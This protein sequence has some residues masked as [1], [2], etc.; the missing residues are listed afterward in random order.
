MIPLMRMG[1]FLSC[2]IWIRHFEFAS[3]GYTRRVNLPAEVRKDSGRAQKNPNHGWP[4]KSVVRKC[5]NK[6][7]QNLFLPFELALTLVFLN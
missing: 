5:F 7:G 4:I 6:Q 3:E 1:P 2:V